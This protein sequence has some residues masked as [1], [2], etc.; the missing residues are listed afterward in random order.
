MSAKQA[1]VSHSCSP[2]E[3]DIVWI[4]TIVAV[5]LGAIYWFFFRD[6]NGFPEGEP[7]VLNIKPVTPGLSSSS[8]KHRVPAKKL[9]GQPLKI[10]FY[11]QTGTAEDFARRLGDDMINYGFAPDVQEVDGFD[12]VCVSF[13]FLFFSFLFFPCFFSCSSRQ[14]G[15]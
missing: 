11:T 4:A 2:M 14:E 15:N 10:L 12:P 8:N 1:L 5:L 9:E 6:D 3:L 7:I 13:F